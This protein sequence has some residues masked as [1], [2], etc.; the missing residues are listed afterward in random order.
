MGE[1][2]P[3]FPDPNIEARWVADRL[4]CEVLMVPGAGHYP[5]AEFPEIVSPAIVEFLHRIS[6]SANDPGL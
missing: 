6:L 1:K 4:K 5:Q 2:D 3:D